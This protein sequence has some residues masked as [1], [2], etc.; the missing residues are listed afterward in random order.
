M[1]KSVVLVPP[2][3]EPL[4]GLLLPDLGRARALG[5]LL[6]RIAAKRRRVD[7]RVLPLWLPLPALGARLEFEKVARVVVAGGAHRVRERLVAELA[8][9]AI[10]VDAEADEIAELPEGEPYPDLG[11]TPLVVY[12]GSGPE[13]PSPCF[14]ARGDGALHRCMPGACGPL[15]N[16]VDRVVFAADA[17]DDP[18]TLHALRIDAAA[19]ADAEREACRRL[20]ARVGA[21]RVRL[22]LADAAGLED[23]ALRTR[24]LALVAT[25]VPMHLPLL[26]TVCRWHELGMDPVLECWAG[27]AI[28][29]RN[30][31]LIVNLGS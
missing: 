2:E 12:A 8:G 18:A 30:Q 28:A 3:L 23:A 15:P 16:W 21:S 17:P 7:L 5:R 10:A 1:V 25:A 6:Q 11:A 14:V 20:V 19:P 9:R 26:A 27:N 22:L 13:P 4:P 31:D 24:L 29:E